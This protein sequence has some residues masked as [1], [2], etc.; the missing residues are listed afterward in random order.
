VTYDEY[1]SLLLAAAAAYDE[2]IKPKNSKRQVFS[3]NVNADH[4]DETDNLYDIVCPV[5]SIQAFASKIRPK[6]SFNNNY[7]KVRMPS[8]KW[9]GLDDKSKAIWDRLDDNTKSIILCYNDKPLVP[10]YPRSSSVQPKAG[11]PPFARTSF[12][13]LPPPTQ[14]YL[15]DISDYDFFLANM[16][17]MHI[18][19]DEDLN[20]QHPSDL[21]PVEEKDDIRLINATRSSS[22]DHMPP[23]NL[24]RIM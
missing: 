2:Q 24:R 7:N 3:N 19:P 13:R 17:D 4:D 10:A 1:S 6:Q 11:Q 5:S 14:A 9:F 20:H 12:G 23:G 8:E 18:P 15:H 21:Q 16:H 22:T